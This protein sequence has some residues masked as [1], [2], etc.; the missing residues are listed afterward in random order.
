[1]CEITSLEY[2]SRS[3]RCHPLQSCR[4]PL[5]TWEPKD[6]FWK[7][8][9]IWKVESSKPEAIFPEPGRLS[10]RPAAMPAVPGAWQDEW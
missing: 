1:M 10:M 8:N 7:L 9:H 3:E 5:Y 2:G 6:L 4:D